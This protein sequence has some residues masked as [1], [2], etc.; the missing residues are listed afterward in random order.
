MPRRTKEDYLKINGDLDRKIHWIGENVPQNVDTRTNY[1]CQVENCKNIWTATYS[2]VINKGSGC[3][4]CFNRKRKEGQY[5]RITKKD[6][7][8]I[9]KD[10]DRKI[11]WIGGDI[12][13]TA[14]MKTKYQCQV[15]YCKY[16]WEACYSSVVTNG[17]G[18]RRCSDRRNSEN[19][20]LKFEDYI[21]INEDL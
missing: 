1:Q 9:N 11:H 8:K 20:K 18:C 15:E 12:P 13:K 4:S 7:L 3:P 6:Y 5:R 21:K 10:L 2:N 14:R 19:R 16:E 17:T